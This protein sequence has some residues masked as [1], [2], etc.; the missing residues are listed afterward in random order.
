MNRPLLLASVGAGLLLAV[1][2]GAY[3]ANGHA[4][5]RRFAEAQSSL[6]A[7][8]SPLI[9]TAQ[10]NN[11][12]DEWPARLE[13]TK[14]GGCRAQVRTQEGDA[15]VTRSG[16]RVSSQG[17]SVPALEA[18][19]TLACPLLSMRDV[20]ADD[21]E[22]TI[23]Q[24]AAGL[25]VDLNVSALSRVDDRVGYIVGARP[26]HAD[27]PQLWFDKETDRPLRIIAQQNGQL[28]DIHLLDSASIATNRLAP[29][30]VSV[31]LGSE[32]QIELRLMAQSP[33]LTGH[34][35]PAAELEEEEE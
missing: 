4:I 19:V 18:F 28:W 20:P 34:E 7:S 15:I 23:S 2:A 16:G 24:L 9:G 25:G 32:R 11:S 27:R 21:A 6:R 31:W 22:T 12:R 13:F 10:L 17:A 35:T 1:P 33:R 29:R 8:A 3:V 30:I 14:G 5:L 26:R